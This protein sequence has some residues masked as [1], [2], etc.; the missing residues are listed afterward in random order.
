MQFIKLSKKAV[1]LRKPYKIVI[2]IVRFFMKVFWGLKIVHP[3]RLNDIQNCIIAP[4]HI[5]LNDPPFIGSIMPI[6]IS[7]LAKSELFKN[8]IFGSII[9]YFNAIPIRRGAIDREA[10]HKVENILKSGKTILIFTEKA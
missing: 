7:F 2:S 8:K 1:K 4:N 6:E 9:S 10:L 3:E 5:S